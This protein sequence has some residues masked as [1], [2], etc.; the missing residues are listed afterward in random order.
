MRCGCGW[1]EVLG[2]DWMW[3]VGCTNQVW[4]CSVGCSRSNVDMVSWRH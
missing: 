4:M 1:L 2:A 3:S